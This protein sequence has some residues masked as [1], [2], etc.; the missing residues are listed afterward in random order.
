MS[1]G[2][3]GEPVFAYPMPDVPGARNLI[4]RRSDPVAWLR[5]QI[6]GGNAAAE[7]LAAVPGVSAAWT[8][9]TS[10]VLEAGDGAADDPWGYTWAAGD[11]RLTRFI[12]RHDPQDMIALAEAHLALLF[13]HGGEHM[14]YSNGQDGNTWDWWIGDCRVMTTLASA[15]RHREGYAEHWGAVQEAAK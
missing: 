15:Y 10:G 13:E 2:P 12:A 11:S 14:C 6:E 9:T 1:D 7:Q 4:P 8:E 3:G 5:R